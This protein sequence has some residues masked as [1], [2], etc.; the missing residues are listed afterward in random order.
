MSRA[1]CAAPITSVWSIDGSSA[2]HRFGL[3]ERADEFPLSGN[4]FAMPG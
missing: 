1:S 3:N 4:E 2:S